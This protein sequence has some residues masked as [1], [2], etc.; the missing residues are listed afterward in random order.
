MT[1]D[2]PI[3]P[4]LQAYVQPWHAALADPSA[5]QERILQQLLAVYAQTDY[6]QQ[7]GA[8][9][10]SSIADFRAAFPVMT[11]ADYERLVHPTPLTN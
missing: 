5:A 9:R 7:H 3:A 10:I 8:E 6:G 4:I 2:N 1:T 11:Y